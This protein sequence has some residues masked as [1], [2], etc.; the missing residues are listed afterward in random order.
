MKVLIIGGGGREHAIAWKLKRDDSAVELV[1]APGNPGIEQ[2]ARCVPVGT[3]DT[4]GLV[5]LAD[6]E[7]PDLIVVGP[8]APLADGL[9]DRLRAKRLRCFGPGKGAARIESS[10][11]F[12]KDLMLRAGVPTANAS[13]H[14]DVDSAKQA[15]R[16]LGAPVVIKAS[17]LAAGKGV[18]VAESVD[19]ADR[20]IDAMLRQRSLGVAGAEVLVEEFMTGEELSIFFVTDGTNFLPMLPAQDHKRLGE[21]DTGPN[22]GGMGAYAPVSIS[23]PALVARV[24]SEIIEPTLVA[25]RELGSPFSGLLYAGI[26]LTPTGP[27]VVEYN[28]RFG[29][30]E[31]EVVLPLM[32]SPLGEVMLAASVENGLA[33]ASPIHFSDSAA[34]TTIVA[35]P[36]YPEKPRTGA[37]IRF[38]SAPETS[39]VFHAGTKRDEFGEL[40]TSGGRVFAVTGLGRSI[41]EAR[42]ASEAGVASIAFDGAYHRR[43]IGWRE[44]SRSAGAA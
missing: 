17:G 14:S 8:E 22:T 5:A 29:D 3:A 9:C 25:L 16:V 15:V 20:A 10:K 18:V 19:D 33:G 30:P 11:T 44:L 32:T 1:A 2:I 40:R 7:R 6:H 41:S 42:R 4:E 31:T 37:P 21:H 23:N 26:M 34:V 24:G 35:S 36:G 43:D 13:W 38:G 12:S 28:C 39:I 27:K